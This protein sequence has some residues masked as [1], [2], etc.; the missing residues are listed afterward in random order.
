MNSFIYA[1]SIV[2]L[3]E[4]LKQS[5]RPTAFVCYSSNE[6]YWVR[7]V[8]IEAGLSVPRDVSILALDDNASN[9]DQWPELGRVTF[10]RYAM[11][12]CAAEMILEML[13]NKGVVPPSRGFTDHRILGETFARPSI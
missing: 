8:C 12:R 7:T 13:G 10:D 3:K 6:A 4:L 9:A 1:E 5:D 11:G 2:S